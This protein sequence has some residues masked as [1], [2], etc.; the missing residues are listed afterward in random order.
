MPAGKVFAVEQRGETGGDIGFQ[1]FDYTQAGV[2]GTPEW[3]QSAKG[4]PYPPNYE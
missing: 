1:P 4:G 3:K 2:Y